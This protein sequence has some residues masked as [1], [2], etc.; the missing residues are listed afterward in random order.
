MSASTL[1]GFFFSFFKP[2]GSRVTASDALFRVFY[3]PPTPPPSFVQIFQPVN[4]R[5]ALSSHKAVRR[6]P[7]APA[8]PGHSHNVLPVHELF[9]GAYRGSLYGGD[10]VASD[11]GKLKCYFKFLPYV[12]E[13]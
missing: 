13:I 8:G 11:C 12:M 7:S 4:M 6:L 10:I 2:F 1:L 9:R 5:A 3:R